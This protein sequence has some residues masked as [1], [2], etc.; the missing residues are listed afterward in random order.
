M[1]LSGVICTLILNS[2]AP[3]L[4]HIPVPGPF[5]KITQQGQS[6]PDTSQQRVEVSD[7]V[8]PGVGN[9]LFQT[10]S[11]HRYL[12]ETNP[13]LTNLKSFLSSNYLLERLGYDPD[14]AQKRLGDGLYAQRLIGLPL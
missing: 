6:L 13:A 12:V 4:A 2:A 8:L 1:P 3:A 7:A 11:S 5:I 14:A 9:G 10:S